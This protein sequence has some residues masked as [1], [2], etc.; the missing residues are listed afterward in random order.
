MPERTLEIERK[1]LCHLL[2]GLLLTGVAA[3]TDTMAQAEWHSIG[4]VTA[5]QV[6]GNRI[7]FLAQHA[8]IQVSVLAPDIVRTRIAQGSSF[9]ADDSWAVVKKQWPAVHVEAR[10]DSHEEVLRTGRLVIRVQLSPFRL[11]FEDPAGRLISKDSDDLGV[12]WNGKQVRCWKHMP[13]DEHY[14]GLGEN[15]GPLDKRGHAYVMWNTDAYGWGAN[16]TPL[17]QT[18]PFF[19]GLRQ[20][21]A[22]GVFFDNTWRSSFDM[23][24][25]SRNEYSFGADDGELN[26]YFFYGPG[27]DKVLQDFTELVGRMHLPPMWSI[28]YNQ[29][30]YSYYPEKKVR[31]IADNF[32]MRKIPCDVIF[33][34]IHYM[35]GYRVFTWN[36]ERFPNPAGMIAD[37]RR[38]GFHLAVIIDP[39]IK[40]DPNYWVY[41]E[42][43]ARNG[44]VRM[45]NGKM[46]VGKVWPGE[47]AFPDFTSPNVRDWWGTLYKGLVEDGVAGFWN[48]MN[49]P[50]VFDV[51]T[52]TMPLDAVFYDHGRDS[53]HT[54]VHN[55]YGML[56]SE[57]TEAGVLK[58]RPDERPF[59][60]TRDTYAGG[61][62]YAAVWTGDNTAAWEHLRISVRELMTMGLSG[63]AFAGADIGGFAGSPS[64]QLYARWLEAGVFYPYCRTHSDL[65]S[66]NQEPWSYGNRMTTINRDSI[67]LRY[68]LLPYI[69][70][71][72]YQ[73]SQ[74][75]LP[76]MR[77]LLLNYPDDSEAVEQEGEFLFGD[78][79]LIA[80][81]M[82]QGKREQKAYLPRGEWFDYW[83]DRE[84]SGP[85]EITVAAP[86]KSIPIFVRGGAII[87]TRQV[88]QYTGEAPI[89]PLTFQVFPDGQSSREY[90]ED[91]GLSFNYRKGVYLRERLADNDHPKTITLSV[92]ARQGNYTPPSRAMQ[93]AVHHLRNR[94]QNVTL[95]GNPLASVETDAD[96]K[97]AARGWYYD[98]VNDILLIKFGDQGVARTVEVEK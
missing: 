16:T 36:K 48:D 17:Y 56:M 21:R 57:A 31:F 77:A 65:D 80:P 14:F 72:F 35:D 98:D 40:V 64:P 1:V 22:Y 85:K 55:V 37:L 74:T 68:R 95:N 29:S 7:T 9:G 11:S 86:L 62:R 87:P 90:Y 47:S 27:P 84:Y 8:V 32:R 39:G 3:V 71:T 60:L 4:K 28:G 91:D 89:N 33:L 42:G 78:D 92:S 25:E 66:A 43:L 76:V 18:V 82:E 67:D 20:G 73:A 70:N 41:K 96:L 44:F 50:S 53:P 34:D 97:D 94:P 54:K 15:A 52:K 93:F 61:Q 49:E 83:T 81:V 19:I 69:Y 5:A 12:A 45:P 13:E 10:H 30:R 26:Y 63:L 6:E 59:V 38:Q 58:L 88:V 51:P 24:V 23:G 75:G 79:L 2:W 46:F